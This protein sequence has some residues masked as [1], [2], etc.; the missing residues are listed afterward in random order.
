MARN[1]T[2][3]QNIEKVLELMGGI[4]TYIDPTDI[5]VLKCNG[6]WPNQG[7]TNTECI[8][9]LADAILSIPGFA[10]EVLICDNIQN[11]E[12]N[13]QCGFI[14]GA[15][16]RTNNWAAHNWSSLASEYQAAGKPV[17][18][19]RWQNSTGNR[20]Y[21]AAEGTGWVRDY[22]SFYGHTTYLS[23]PIFESPLT[24]G[25]LIDMKNG[26]WEG[27]P[28]GGYT[29]QKVKTIFMPTLNN[30]GYGKE[31][32]AGITSAV[33][34]FFG[35]TEIH[36]GDDETVT[37]DG[38]TCRHM[39]S[40]SYT[41]DHAYYAGELAARYI[42]TMYRPVLYITCAI[43]SGH[44]SRTGSASFT[45]TVLACENPSTLDYVACKHVMPLALAPWLDP[46]NSNNTR[47]QILGCIDGGIGTIDASRY[48]IVSYDFTP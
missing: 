40:S 16:Y 30:H 46:D 2:V 38:H 12:Y 21:S 11:K 10:G 8:K 1:G 42:H 32:Y 15:S 20:I 47:K 28:G 44:E 39:H 14:A 4:I 48:D 45:K 27:G 18:I 5:V 33:K 23:Y 43:W 24:S 41:I 25:R 34:C 9:Y 29:G 13:D 19:F 17:A 22:F 7:Y 31:D 36:N 6:Q 35:A 37:L 3:Q 26:V